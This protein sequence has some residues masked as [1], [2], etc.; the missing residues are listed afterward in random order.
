MFQARPYG[1]RMK[2]DLFTQWRNGA[3]AVAMV[4]P[5]GA[6]KTFIMADIVNDLGWTS[7]II[8]HRREL[9]AQLSLSLA[10]VGVE[11][12][13]IAS[14]STIQFIITKHI[15]V[16]GRSLVNRKAATTV[17]SAQTLLSRKDDLVQW[18]A[19]IQLWMIDECHHVLCDNTWG[20]AV[21]MFPNARGAGFTAS[22]VRCDRKSLH[23]SQG[24]VFDALVE[25]PTMRWLIDNGFLCD[26]R[27]V[28]PLKT[29]DTRGVPV[30]KTTGDFTRP[31]L[32]KAIDK[33]EI[34][35]DIVATYLKFA[36]GKQGITFTVSVEHAEQVAA[37]YNLAGVPAAFV[38]GNTPEAIRDAIIEKFRAGILKQLVNVDLFGEGFDVPNVEVVSFARPTQSFGLFI[39]Q[40]GRCLRTADGKLLALILDHVGNVSRH[41]LP[42][43]ERVWSLLAEERGKRQ[44]R[45]PDQLPT[46][47]CL[48]P[49]C[50]SAYVATTNVCPFCGH[51]NEPEDRSGPAQ[52]SGDLVELSP[53]VLQ[54]M[55][56]AANSLMSDNVKVPAHLKDTPAALA[57]VRKHGERQL[58]QTD[59]RHQIALWA[60]VRKSQG[61]SDSEIQRRFFHMFEI[62]VLGA[63]ALGRPAAE[64]LSEQVKE[65]VLK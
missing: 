49:E 28:V 45:D 6:G 39:Q 56:A 13:I 7:C 48:N 46:T 58:A 9:I 11:H 62:D 42:D 30:S 63:Q 35:G 17:T 21:A 3:N 53:E 18:A 27:I 64:K 29:L 12:N 16:V 14:A 43:A 37:A 5:T 50:L 31:G 10:I 47:S 26:Y 52:V 25:G 54:K 15:Q 41:G 55:R 59:L 40:F 57:L 23:V 20:M 61:Q 8:A 24:G 32:Q 1:I 33:S 4:A 65:R 51:V 44:K 22:P 2:E 38:S 34:T 19:S 36:P 60:G